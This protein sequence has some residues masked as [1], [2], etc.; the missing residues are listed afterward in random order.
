MAVRGRS[1]VHAGGR[2]QCG[3]AARRG[4]AAHSAWRRQHGLL[5]GTEVGAQRSGCSLKA[6]CTRHPLP[7]RI[8]ALGQFIIVWQII[9]VKLSCRAFCLCGLARAGKLRQLILGSQR[10][11]RHGKRL[12]WPRPLASITVWIDAVDGP[13][14]R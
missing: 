1:M 13:G 9:K 8:S 12:S 2:C 7:R 11:R 5:D 3:R 6:N 14:P 10:P 4:A